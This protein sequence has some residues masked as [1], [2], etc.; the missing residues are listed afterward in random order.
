MTEI[1]GIGKTRAKNLLKEMGSIEKIKA[2]SVEQLSKVTGM[3]MAAAENIKK[4]FSRIP[5]EHK[6]GS[7]VRRKMPAALCELTAFA[8]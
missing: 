4:Y 2:A 7:Q 5:D 6:G 3:N 1:E 8:V